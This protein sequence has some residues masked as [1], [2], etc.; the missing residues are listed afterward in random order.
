MGLLKKRRICSRPSLDY[1]SSVLIANID[2]KYSYRDNF[3]DFQKHI[4]FLIILMY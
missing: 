3:S 1:Q 2:T 4:D